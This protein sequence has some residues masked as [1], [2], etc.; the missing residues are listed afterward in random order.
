MKQLIKKIGLL[1]IPFLVIVA[2]IF[3]FT[4]QAAPENGA[5]V[6]YSDWYYETTS[7]YDD[8]YY[9][10]TSGYDDWY[11]D[12]TYGYDYEN[13][14]G[15]YGILG[16]YTPS[17]GVETQRL[18]FAMPAAWQN[19]MTKDPR[20]GGAA[21]C[22][23][24][25]G[26][27]TPDNKAGGHGWPGYKTRKVNEN[28][29]DNLYYIDVP[30]YGNGEAGNTTMII[31]D[32]YLDAGMETNPA[33]NP[34][35]NAAQQTIDTPAQYYSRYDE[36][37]TYDILFRYIYLKAFGQCGIDVWNLD[38]R[39]NNFWQQA[40]MIAAAYLG[41]DWYS[42]NADEKTYQVDIILDDMYDDIDLSEFGAYADNFFNEDWVGDAYYPH[43]ECMGFGESFTFD[44]M[45]YVVSFDPSK[46]A[47]NP[48]SGKI[49]Y[50]GDF[51][52]YYGGGEYGSWPT[53]ELN[54]QMKAYLGEENV[55][56]GNFTT[57]K[58]V[59]PN[60]VPP[61]PT[62]DPYTYPTDPLSPYNPAPGYSYSGKIYFQ[63][64]SEW[65]N[66]KKITF[67]LED[68]NTGDQFI[69]WGSKKGYMTD[70]G[71]GIWSYNLENAGL[72][73]DSNRNY[74]CIFTADWGVETCD[75]I[76]GPRSMGDTA[77][78]TGGT[79]ENRVDSNKSSYIVKWRSGNYGNPVCI[80]SIG[81]V[82]GD[83]YWLGENAVSVFYRFISTTD[84]FSIKNATKFNGKTEQQTIDDIAAKL[85]LSRAQVAELVARAR[86][87]GANLDW[88]DGSS[89][90]SDSASGS[91]YYPP[92]S[93]SFT[94]VKLSDGTYELTDYSGESKFVAIPESVRERI[95]M[96][97]ASTDSAYNNGYVDVPVTSIG[98]WTF[99]NNKY[100]QNIYIPDTI[101]HIGKGTFYGCVGL[102][103]VEIPDS[104]TSI[105]ASAFERCLALEKV[106]LG[107]GITE[108]ADDTFSDC[109][110]LSEINI[111][112]GVTRIGEEAF[113]DCR[114]LKELV[115]PEGLQTIGSADSLRNMGVFEECRSLEKIRIPDSVTTIGEN[116][117]EN[118]RKLTVFGKADSAAAD[119][120]EENDINF[121]KYGRTTD[122]GKVVGDLNDD[123]DVNI[124]DATIMQSAFAEMTD[125]NLKDKNNIALLD[126]NNDGKVNIRDVT[127]IQRYIAE[128]I[129]EI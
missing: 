53:K 50:G 44:N 24:W 67:F 92:T 93:P 14:S 89:S 105:D 8:W 57:G 6:S 32:N 4:A 23:W 7:G 126:T 129:K 101:K 110:Y 48:V 80:T 39:S 47:K 46:M 113:F 77:Y 87:A 124:F 40:N 99:Y 49:G 112:D 60:L 20:C 2:I 121:K 103:K 91:G 86:N 81:N 61:T 72:S 37:E 17:T 41:E 29:V 64:P 69:T 59:D 26:Y 70:E 74:G 25:S 27:D 9:E 62:D 35:Y 45:V 108:I 76:I 22:Y 127:Q 85:G 75:L 52:F 34:F 68:H 19:N 55:V 3:S 51:Y 33:K 117:F 16:T 118:C 66:F 100:L 97:G 88:T 90:T 79:V 128:Y 107:N 42:L 10:T 94:F 119:F 83:H 38:I 116:A 106:T 11:D 114:S 65:K 104:V 18:M 125:I 31:W 12:T 95:S 120:A 56:S 122:S 58:F 123:W 30:T 36:H 5:A 13:D 15:S 1:S 96:N 82:I 73:L 71:G 43:E 63:V 84:A 98:D 109:R 54:E 111:P 28:D 21:G 78:C 102:K 115:L